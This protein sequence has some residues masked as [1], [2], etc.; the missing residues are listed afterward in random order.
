[1]ADKLR[2]RVGLIT[3]TASGIGK[4]GALLFAHEGATLVT[5]DISDAQGRQTVSEIEAADGR[6]I[7][8]HGDVAKAADIERAVRAAVETY[9]KLD[10]LW[11]NAGIPVFKTIVDT[12]E[13]EWDRI[14]D[15][16]LKGSYLV[17][18]YGIP[19]LLRAGGGTMVV[20]ASISSF[21][22]AQ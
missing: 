13:E 3:G 12:T 1:M 18:K 16:N 17:A 22:G 4:A 21:V 5:L 7:F 8:V 15:V 19:E 10:L 14:V 11:S 2:G 9:G 20:T 6:A